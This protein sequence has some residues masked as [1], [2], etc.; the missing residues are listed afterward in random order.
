M[1]EARQQ[2]A[3]AVFV[4][5]RDLAFE[6]RALRDRMF[7]RWAARLMGM[8][9]AAADAY[10]RG[11][12]LSNIDQPNDGR[13]LAIALGDFDKRGLS[14]PRASKERLQRKLERLRAV[15]EAHVRG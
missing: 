9:G 7:G 14:A 1:F 10:A 13:L 3:E 2:A 11:M 4:H 8:S 12:M 5:E 6:A 15:A